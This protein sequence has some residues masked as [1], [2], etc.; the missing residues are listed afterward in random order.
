[1]GGITI[2]TSEVRALAA[3]MRQ[4]D[5]RLTR[6]V[7]PVVERGAMNVREQLRAEAASSAHFRMA[8][9]ITYDMKYAGFGAGGVIEAE[10]GP[11]KAGAGNLANIAYFGGANG[12]GGTVP[13]PQGAADSELPRFA[14]ALA[15]IAAELAL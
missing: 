13:D 6:H 2:D 11:E 3:D 4:V 15:D 12:G 5:H 8:R 9:H 14:K 7:V 10:V 1:M